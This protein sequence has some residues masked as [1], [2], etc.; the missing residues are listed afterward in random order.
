MAT[1]RERKR[2]YNRIWTAEK[3]KR[4][5]IARLMAEREELEQYLAE[6]ADAGINR[7]E[8]L[9]ESDTV[10]ASCSQEQAVLEPGEQP[11]I[12]ACAHTPEPLEQPDESASDTETGSE[13]E[14]DSDED[15]DLW[16]MFEEEDAQ[17]DFRDGLRAW[18]TNHQVKHSAI[19]ALLKLLRSTLELD[20]P[21]TARTLLKTPRDVKIEQ[22]SGGDY[23]YFG[24][25]STL[26]ETLESYPPDITQA[27][28]T[29]EIGLNVDGLPIFKSSKSSLWPV[30][31]AVYLDPVQV[32][33]CR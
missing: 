24:L 30:L 11:L 4:Q 21:A 29:V 18:A 31:S 8:R 28:D 32:I 19:D 20:V 13:S 23:H 26:K 2:E 6:A 10:S 7:L 12:E 27:V 33:R 3:R 5:K 25:Q 14:E 9:T 16:D 22:K 1:A 15:A 17:A